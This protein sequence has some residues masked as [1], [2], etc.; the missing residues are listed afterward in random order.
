MIVEFNELKNNHSL[1]RETKVAIKE[2]GI[3]PVVL[4]YGEAQIKVNYIDS[5]F[6]VTEGQIS[7]EQKEEIESLFNDEN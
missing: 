7:K 1:L 2:D 4:M 6:I 3:I 5:R